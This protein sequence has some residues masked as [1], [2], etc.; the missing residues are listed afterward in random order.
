[1]NI[2][3]MIEDEKKWPSNDTKAGKFIAGLRELYKDP[4]TRK[5]INST[6]DLMLCTYAEA[7]AS[8]LPKEWQDAYEEA[9]KIDSHG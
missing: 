8:E 6:S 7:Y 4:Q 5:A 9:K 3:E 1:M 2:K